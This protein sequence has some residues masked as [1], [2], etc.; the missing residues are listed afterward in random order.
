MAGKD[1]LFLLPAGFEDPAL[2]S[3][4]TGWFCPGCAM[5]EGFLGY[6]PRVRERLEVI[7]HPY[8][9][10]REAIVAL[11]G[12]A[13]QGM[14]LLVLAEPFDHP[15][16]RRAENGVCFVADEKPITRYLAACWGLAAPHP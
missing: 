6:H 7:Y 2:D 11:V 14:P 5:V 1:R 8:P 15:D 4:G 3:G 16:V 13:H 9:R 12:E 10:P